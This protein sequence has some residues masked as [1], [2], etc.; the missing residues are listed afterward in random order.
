MELIEEQNLDDK[1]SIENP[2]QTTVDEITLSKTP[3][4]KY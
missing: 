2:E 3:I 1:M 4:S